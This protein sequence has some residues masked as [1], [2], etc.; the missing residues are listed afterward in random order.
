MPLNPTAVRPENSQLLLRHLISRYYNEHMS[1]L[2]APTSPPHAFSRDDWLG[3]AA[4]L[5]AAALVAAGGSMVGMESVRGWYSG[6]EKPA[7]S[8]PNWLFGPVWTVL[9]LM[10]SLAAWMVW[11]RRGQEFARLALCIYA[12]QLLLNA[13]WSPLFF[14]LQN[15]TLALLDCIA[16][17][18]AIATTIA[19]FYQVR[20]LAAWLLVPYLL[21]V[22]FALSLNAAIVALN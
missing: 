6:L 8:P 15:P 2:A 5:I 22:S 10:M 14:A 4:L 16:L 13:A 1:D 7:W 19:L 20:S 11:L 3:L 17:W 18:I 12:F 21:W 9:Y